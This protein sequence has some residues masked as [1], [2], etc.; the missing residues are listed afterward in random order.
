[1][2]PNQ[3]IMKDLESDINVPFVLEINPRTKML[4]LVAK[5][6]MRKKDFRTSNKVF[7]VEDF[8]SLPSLVDLILLAVALKT[9]V[10]GVRVLFKTAQGYRKLLRA[11]DSVGVKLAN[12]LQREDTKDEMMDRILASQKNRFW[13]AAVEALHRLVTSQSG[14]Q[15]LGGYAF[16]ISKS[17][18]DMDS[19][20]L[21]SAY[22]Q[23]YS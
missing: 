5:S 14:R 3:A 15:S 23:K 18:K 13:D 10:A 22:R 4:D 16:D 20:E 11:A 1:M 9:T 19:K 7:A 21:I 12:K 6:V 2:G 8:G 17:F